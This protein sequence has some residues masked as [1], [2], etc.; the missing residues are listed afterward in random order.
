MSPN[1][2][3]EDFMR[4]K[5]VEKMIL[6]PA[7]TWVTIEVQRAFSDPVSSSERQES[8]KPANNLYV[9]NIMKIFSPLPGEYIASALKRG[10]E[11]L[12]IKSL[13]S[14][15]FYIKPIPR[16]GFGVS[17]SAMPLK[18]GWRDHPEFKFPDFIET[19]NISEQILM[20]HTLHPINAALG[21]SRAYTQ[22]T[23]KVWMRICPECV[24]EDIESHG[25]PYIHT[26]HVLPFVMVCSL[27]SIDLVDLCP[28]CLVDLRKHDIT[29]LGKCSRRYKTSKLSKKQKASTPR[30]YAKFIADLLDYRGKMVLR[31]KANAVIHQSAS[32]KY[33]H[34]HLHPLSS[35]GLA[36]VIQHEFG[37]SATLD[38]GPSARDRVIS[39]CAFLG[40][41]T[42]ETYFELLA[43]EQAWTKLVSDLEY[44]GIHR[45]HNY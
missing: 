34:R 40:C 15:D 24:L 9:K 7:G 20:N 37:I 22:V 25:S 36:K 18:A 44:A 43:F 13:S 5:S 14:S 30:L 41:K 45:Y 38:K 39:L 8:R 28:H 10:N 16:T 4:A 11:L 29:K 35:M 1:L 19:H 12:G 17:K 23:P 31:G 21:R 32:L 26:R 33:A 2:D 42:A 6:S 27:H 3:A